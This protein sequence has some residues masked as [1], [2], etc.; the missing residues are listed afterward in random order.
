MTCTNKLEL[1]LELELEELLEDD[2]KLLLLEDSLD[3]DDWEDDELDKELDDDTD[4]EL[5]EL[6]S[7]ASHPNAIDK[8]PIELQPMDTLLPVDFA[9]PKF[10]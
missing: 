1:L 9:R 6:S 8:L 3:D 5:D 7:P 4:E 10:S 2:D